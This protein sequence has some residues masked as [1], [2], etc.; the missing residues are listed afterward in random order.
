MFCVFRIGEASNPGPADQHPGLILG[1]INPTGLPNKSASLLELP[2]S[3]QSIWGVS[4]SHLTRPGLVKFKKEL[5]FRKLDLQFHPG[6]PVPMRSQVCSAIGG[7]QLGV[8]FLS[9]V[10]SKPLQPT[11]PNSVWEE[12]RFAMNTFFC[13]GQWIHGA[14]IYGYASGSETQ[15]VR[16][17]T[18]KLLELATDRI[19][20]QLQGKRFITGDFNQ[21]DG[22]LSQPEAWKAA[23]WKEVQQLM[24]ER[25][26]EPIAETCKGVTRKDFLWISPELVEDFQKVEIIPHVFPDHSVIAAFFKL[27]NKPEP[28]Y[29]WRKPKPISWEE[30]QTCLP[31]HE[32]KMPEVDAMQQS[33]ALAKEFEHRV[34]TVMKSKNMMMH[35]SQKGRGMTTT[36]V[37]KS[38]P[39]KPITRGR[40]GSVTTDFN[41]QSHAHAKWFRQ[42]RRLESLCQHVNKENPSSAAVVHIEREWR[43]ICKATGFPTTKPQGDCLQQ[44]YTYRFSDWWPS[45]EHKL[46]DAPTFLPNLPP[47]PSSA[48]A[49]FLTFEREFRAFEHVLC[50]AFKQKARCNRLS[51]PN[52]VFK[53]VRKPPV[54]PVTMLDDSIAVMI[55]ESD[56]DE[57]SLTLEHPTKFDP[58]VPI[59]TSKGPISPIVITED[60]IWVETN[61]LVPAGSMLRQDKF[62]GDLPELF[63]RFSAEWS[64]RWDKHRE[65]D[66]AY[67]DP[68][69]SFLEQSLGSQ[70]KMELE[71]ISPEEWLNT[72][73]KKK[74]RAATGPDGWARADL[75]A[76]PLNLVKHLL[77]ILHAIEN[78]ELTEWPITWVTGFVHSLEKTPSA[79]LVTNYR[80]ITVF[81]LIYRTW[82][83][84]R[85]RQCLRHL[86]SKAPM[87][88]YGNMPKRSASQLWYS[89][90]MEI[91]RSYEDNVPL[92]GCAMD[93]VKAFNHIPRIPIIRAS[94]ILGIAPQVVRAWSKAL[95]SLERR[96]AIRGSV[97]EPLKS[98]TGL[99]E[100]CAMS[101]V[102][103]AV[104]NFIVNEW[105]ARK[106][107]SVCLWSFVDNWEITAS[108]A[109]EVH[110]GLQE[111][112]KIVDLLDLEL[113]PAKTVLWATS[114]ECRQWL[115]SH[116]HDVSMWAKDLGA[117]VQYSQQCT[118]EVIVS[119]IKAFASRWADFHRSPATYIQKL[120]AICAV[121][122]PNT[123]H[124]IS[125]VHL[126]MDHV[127]SLRTAAMRA[128]REHGSGTSPAIHLALVEAPSSDPGFYILKQTV[129]DCRNQQTFESV[130]V[131]MDHLVEQ[132]RFRPP[133]GPC[134]VLLAR[135][136]AIDWSWE[137]NQGFLD[138]WQRPINI[139]QIPIQELLC[140]LSEAWQVN[141]AG[142]AAARKTFTGMSHTSV[143]LSRAFSR[144]PPNQA[145]I[146]RK[147]MNGSFFTA[148]HE[149]YI[150][151]AQGDSMCKFCGQPDSVTHRNWECPKL[152]QARGQCDQLT[153]DIILQQHPAFFNHG[154]APFPQ[155]LRTFQTMLL[156]LPRYSDPI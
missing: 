128:L 87:T 73:R 44:C 35:H 48:K 143:Y 30:V 29:F 102:G 23:G 20:N 151:G 56:P 62:V 98:S 107:P 142:R 27:P 8:G 146:L 2:S 105:M 12:A 78:N 21:F 43:A 121:S 9:S 69:V 149:K 34:E 72:L 130:Q 81:S 120:R 116:G 96:F 111:I 25:Y 113:D 38:T 39:S 60:K 40:H 97:G 50:Q 53:D 127:D 82:G 132:S 103:M 19:V 123:L 104:C 74:S 76:M 75:I 118:N 67:W 71:P 26:G 3:R 112:R 15:Q 13:E 36:V 57:C 79:R 54:S 141:V 1:A 14:V 150:E 124:G 83:S 11:W 144:P 55:T 64:K 148:D 117:H 90:Q 46:G 140:R 41:G 126:G 89:I 95:V 133:P 59:T 85:A 70:P 49:I 115:R 93:I 110:Q 84:I 145:A 109:N 125:S 17:A 45:I 68:I 152:E 122:W 86:V 52:Q 33:I 99:A 134:S 136:Q 61:D 32:W 139:W 18:D 100:G 156:G 31:D 106:Q 101:V 119:K 135:L 138:Q 16:Q 6:A 155:T 58:D 4:E 91:E 129:L 51:D 131:R 66:D 65:T 5:A 10:P 77:T 92:A 80:P 47:T 24:H 7:K 94:L 114:S 63:R 137:P 88:C 42:M 37:Q 147:A 153:R 154:W 108:N 22:A 28:F